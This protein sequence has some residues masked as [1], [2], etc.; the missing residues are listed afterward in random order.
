[1]DSVAQWAFFRL[2]FDFLD[3]EIVIF[4]DNLL[5]SMGTWVMSIIMVLVTIWIMIQ[6][7]MIV[8]GRSRE[9]MMALVTGALRVVLIVTA[10]SALTAANDQV[11]STLSNDVPRHVTKLV[12]GNDADAAAMIDSNINKMSLAFGLI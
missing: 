8:T 2:I 3:K 12:T 4:Q 6:G 1:M 7:F 9:P 10:A 5:F 11:Y